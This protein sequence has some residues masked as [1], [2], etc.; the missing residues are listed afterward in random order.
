[1]FSPA[2]TPVQG[3]LLAARKGLR[4][5]L[6]WA[7]GL[8]SFANLAALVVPLY[9]IQVYD[10]VLTSR[11][12]TTL[13]MV[14]AITVFILVVHAVLDGL[15]GTILNR[16]SVGFDRELAAPVFDAAFR[17]RLASAQSSEGRALRDVEVI[18]NFIASGGVAALLDLPWVPVFIALSFAIH[19]MLGLVA[20]VGS[21]LIA[22]TALAAEM[23]T[24]APTLASAQHGANA[25]RHCGAVLR[26]AEMIA[27]LGMKATMTSIWMRHHE[28][29]LAEQAASAGLGGV[30]LATTKLIRFAVQIAI[31]GV[32]AWLVIGGA[33]NAG[34][35]FAASLMIGRALAPVEQ[36]VGSWR[37]I[38]AAR[39]AYQTLRQLFATVPAETVPL[40]LPRPT[41]ALAI[42]GTYVRA[43]GT[44]HPLVRNVSLSVKA[45]ETLVVVGASG[46]G[47]S[48][49]VRA[50]TGVWPV[51]TG[52]VRLDGAAL[53]QWNADHLGRHVGYL[54]QEVTLFEGTVAQNIARHGTP[55]A[56]A[57]V[58]AARAAGVHE[59]I[60][61]LPQ[62][63]ETSV[64]VAGETLS[65]GMRQRVALAR[66]LYGDP[67]LIILDEPNSNLDGAGDQALSETLARL[68]GAGKTVVVVS[69]K[70]GLIGAADKMLVMADGAV[71][72]FG[73]RDEVLQRIGR[74][75][76]V[77]GNDLAV[78]RA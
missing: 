41:G 69:H 13:A 32:A 18:R 63:Y 51:S 25:Q 33:I 67:C 28:A 78:A 74:P 38:V 11:N 16:A 71:H 3:P 70:M 27:A 76:V 66:A 4:S 5:A 49:L 30:L 6:G 8:S 9:S 15:R 59:A 57:V 73:N 58:A 54:P 72:A 40:E 61:R 44:R 19:P 56:L 50:L 12:L 47:K 7:A 75:R 35:I 29:S 60:L 62:G 14:T 23:L 10:R 17:S 68:K 45:G 64:G 21:I 20:L 53:S 48:T 1:M 2:K 52:A 65:G 55:D 46:S 39:E 24:R 37:R 34:V 31:M 43:P 26:D 77:A 36:T 42:E 22:A